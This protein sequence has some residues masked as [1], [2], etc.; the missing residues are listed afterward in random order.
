MVETI[1]HADEESWR[2]DGFTF[3]PDVMNEDEVRELRS[4]LDA[5]VAVVAAGGSDFTDQGNKHTVRIKAAV[6]RTPL[7]DSLLDHPR[8]L[9][10][11]TRLLQ[12]TPTLL[13]SEVFYRSPEQAPMVKFHTDGGPLLQRLQLDPRECAL[14]LKVQVFL[15]DV[16]AP[17]SGNFMLVRG[18]HIRRPQAFDPGCYLPEANAYLERG[19]LPPDTVQICAKAG[20][21]VVFPYS[22]WH[23]VAPNETGTIRKSVILRFGPPW[24]RP[25]DSG[26]TRPEVIARMPEQRRRILGWREGN[27]PI[28]DCYKPEEVDSY[29]SAYPNRIV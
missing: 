7:L 1:E 3:L 27:R 11:L 14:Q 28:D 17:N 9:P 26:G 8:L 16:N 25:H 19:E 20:D 13:G 2:N 29:W 12:S 10:T 23:A 4:Q 5:F 18:S 21:A 6:A 15:T 24:C 22:L